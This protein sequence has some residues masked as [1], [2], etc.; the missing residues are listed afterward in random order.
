MKVIF[1]DIDGVLNSHSWNAKNQN[2]ISR[3]QLIDE[4]AVKLLVRIV[5]ETNAVIVL[6]S[7]WRFW[8]DTMLNPLREEARHL[9]NVLQQNGLK[10]YD[11]TP[12][13]TTDE[14]RKTGKFSL[15]KAQEI[16]LWIE[17]N[18]NLEGYVVLD[19]MELGHDRINN[20]LILIN[21]D[22][23]ISEDDVCR[24]VAILKNNLCECNNTVHKC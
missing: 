20:R 12:D 1:L 3:G 18:E 8:F 11:I 10:I 14:I 19:D 9:I 21:A 2:E 15:V 24:A 5:Y 7:G 16:L 23:G 13:L 17:R 22:T 4:S 6:H